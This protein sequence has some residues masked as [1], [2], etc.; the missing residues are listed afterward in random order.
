MGPHPPLQEFSYS[1]KDTDRF[2]C[3]PESY[4]ITDMTAESVAAKVRRGWIQR[5][6]VPDIITIVQGQQFE[7]HFFH[8]LNAYLGIQ[9][10]RT[11]P[12]HPSAKSFV[13]RTH[14]SHNDALMACATSSWTL[15]LPFAL[16]GLSSVIK[17]HNTF[18]L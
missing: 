15:L 11:T 14:M 8:E 1:L 7:S 6:L 10:I 4:P 5:F 9:K 17:E 3:S 13:E 18:C 16:L 12:Y 2:I